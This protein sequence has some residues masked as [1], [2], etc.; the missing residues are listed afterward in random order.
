MIK[1]ILAI[2]L[3]N[4]NKDLHVHMGVKRKPRHFK[5][6]SNMSFLFIPFTPL[7]M[8]NFIHFKGVSYLRFNKQ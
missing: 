3:N 1:L 6:K 2:T 7:F 5:S 8:I 4:F